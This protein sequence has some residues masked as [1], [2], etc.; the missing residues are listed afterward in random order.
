MRFGGAIARSADD[1]PRMIQYWV[2]A[3]THAAFRSFAATGSSD[4][5]QIWRTENLFLGSA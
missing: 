3:V 2:A 5:R 1:K 4:R